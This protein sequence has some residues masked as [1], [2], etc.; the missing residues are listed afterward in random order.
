MQ[1]SAGA[2]VNAQGAFVQHEHSLTALWRRQLNGYA[3]VQVLEMAAA[4]TTL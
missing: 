2:V 1:G 3:C 4:V